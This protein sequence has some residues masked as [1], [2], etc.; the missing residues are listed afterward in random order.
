[1]VSDAAGQPFVLG[2][3][4][5]VPNSVRSQDGEGLVASIRPERIVV[6]EAFSEPGVHLGGVVRQAMFTG[7]EL[8]LTI[9][10][11]GH[12]LLDALTEPST[13]MIALRPG[14]RVQLGVRAEDFLYF[15]PG[16][17]GALLQ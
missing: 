13:A 7:R 17:T 11:A 10:V 15:A 3:P 16:V 12:G 5:E 6:N 14:D 4:V 1:V 8:Q 2:Q 9:E